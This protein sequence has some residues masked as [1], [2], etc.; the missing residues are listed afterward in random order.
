MKLH[1]GLVLSPTID[2]SEIGD[3]E[4]LAIIENFHQ[5]ETKY[6]LYEMPHRSGVQLKRSLAKYICTL[7]TENGVQIDL[8]YKLKSL[9]KQQDSVTVT[10]WAE[11]MTNNTAAQSIYV[12][13]I[14]TN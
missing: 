7:H 6:R 14:S 8:F 3:D 12:H 9:L 11:A 4:S 10:K 2:H 5:H 13:I 1:Y